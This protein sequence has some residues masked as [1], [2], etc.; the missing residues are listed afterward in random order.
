MSDRYERFSFDAMEQVERQRAAANALAC[1][2]HLELLK[3]YHSDIAPDAAVIEP[4]PEPEPEP[5][6]V[7]APPLARD[8]MIVG[9]PTKL[10]TIARQVCQKHRISLDALKNKMRWASHVKARQ[11]FCWRAR[12]E[13]GKSFPQIGAFINRDHTTVMHSAR[14]YIE[15]MEAAAE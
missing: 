11:E 2:K 7:V 10:D 14:K 6:P 15:T 8:W 12:R 3:L 1:A 5:Q 13:T 4:E 9:D